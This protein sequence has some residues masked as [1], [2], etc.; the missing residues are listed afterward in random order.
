[1]QYETVVFNDAQIEMSFCDW[2][3]VSYGVQFYSG[4]QVFPCFARNTASGFFVVRVKVN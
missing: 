3:P 2:F 1:M 4:K